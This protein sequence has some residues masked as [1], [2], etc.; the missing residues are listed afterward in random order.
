M[1]HTP[2]ILAP[3]GDANSFLAAISAGADAVYCGLKHFSARMQAENFSIQELAGL[4]ALAHDKGFEVKGTAWPIKE[5]IPLWAD[6]VENLSIS[7][8]LCDEHGNV[9]ATSTKKYPTQ[10]IPAAGFPVDLT[11]K[12]GGQPS[13]GYYV[14][15]GYSTMFTAAKPPA[16]G[17]QGSGG[18][19]GNYVFFANEQ[20][21]LTR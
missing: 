7:A 3:A 10:K 12:H 13:G 2:D 1:N 20:A 6:T 19:A 17:G 16:T 11:L 8:Y 9:L 15:F 4:T 14:T 5:N 18:I 21:A